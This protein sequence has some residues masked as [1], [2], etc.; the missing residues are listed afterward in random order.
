MILDLLHL[1]ILFPLRPNARG[2]QYLSA[3]TAVVWAAWVVLVP[4][5]SGSRL[6]P[7]PE[8][9]GWL[10]FLNAGTCALSRS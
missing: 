8:H 5:G 1:F 4:A 6:A 10:L 7:T 3:R 2:T 9:S